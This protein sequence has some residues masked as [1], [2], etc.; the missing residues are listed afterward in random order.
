MDGTAVIPCDVD[1]NPEQRKA[2]MEK[3]RQDR[4][5]QREKEREEKENKEAER[6]R[7]KEEAAIRSTQKAVKTAEKNR[8]RI[9]GEE[10]RATERATKK[11]LRSQQAEDNLRKKQE[12]AAAKKKMKNEKEAERKFREDFSLKNFKHVTKDTPDPRRVLDIPD[13]QKLCRERKLND[14]TPRMKGLAAKKVLLKRLKIMDE[15]TKHN[16]LVTQ[17][18]N[19]GIPTGG[20]K[21][22]MAYQLALC[23]ARNCDS[24]IEDEVDAGEID[25][26]EG[27]MEVDHPEA[28][29]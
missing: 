16:D 6:Q 25:M 7:I 22:Q 17:C 18:R 29:Q 8:A 12:L 19:L 24:Y 15:A 10:A 3:F 14:H 11:A 9:I 1:D 28:T 20:T 26:V 23:A 13:L 2:D 4:E 5:D 27:A 21:I